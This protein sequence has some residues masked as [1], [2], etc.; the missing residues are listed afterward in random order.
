MPDLNQLRDIVTQQKK[1]IERLEQEANVIINAD[2]SKENANLKKELELS[3]QFLTKQSEKLKVVEEQNASLKNALFEQIYSEKLQILDSVSKKN[4]IYFKSEAAGELNRLA[5]LNKQ[6][7]GKTMKLKDQLKKYDDD[8]FAGL[9]NQLDELTVQANIA[10][11]NAKAEAESSTGAYTAYS[12]EQFEALK[13]EQITDDVV[14]EIGR[15]NNLEA[16][17][18]GNLINKAGIVFVILGI[19]AV[20]QLTFLHL[21][22]TFR[23]IIMFVISGVFLLG[24]E[25]LNRKKPNIFSLGV[26]SVGVAGIYASLSISYFIFEIITMIPALLLCILITAGAFVL[27]RRYSSQTIAIFALVGGYIP[28]IS[29]GDSITLI[30]SAMIYFIV[31]NLFSLALSFY[32][33]WKISMYF[34]FFLNLFGTIYIIFRVDVLWWWHNNSIMMSLAT[35]A[36]IL[37]AFAVY[38]FIPVL[39]NYRT[40]IPFRASDIVILSINTAVSGLIMYIVLLMFNFEAFT[41]AMA[42][43]FAVVYIGLGRFMERYFAIE[44]YMTALF[45]ITGLTFVVLVI[46]LQFG[47]MWLSLGWLTQ[48]VS[49]MCFGIL[50][51][52]KRL[53]RV[54]II[55]GGLCLFSFVFFDMLL[56]I[57]N[58]F[59][60]KYLAITLGSITVLAALMYKKSLSRAGENAY[61]YIVISNAWIYSMYL[62][63]RLEYFLWFQMREMPL[64]H[65]FLLYSIAIVVT[66]LFVAVV[67]RIPVILDTGV[68]VIMMCISTLGMMTLL[69]TSQTFRFADGELTFGTM[70]IATG[71]LIA[72]CVLAMFALRNVLMFFVLEKRLSVEWLP[73]GI[74][75][76]FLIVLTQNLIVQYDLAVTSMI[77]S[78]IFVIAALAWIIYG[79][80]KRFAFMRRF[81]LLL[82]VIAVAKLFLIDLQDLTQVSRIISFFAFGVTLLGISFV[83]QYFSKR[84]APKLESEYE[85]IMKGNEDV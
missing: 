12:N 61:K 10:F 34:G 43:I 36:Y 66:F 84:L 48:A 54:G 16:F 63:S 56:Q 24:G 18:G 40:K 76:F 23:A 75:A 9:F 11:V 19:I 82:S 29:I 6:L 58:L 55:I 60:Y 3:R 32:K 73:F 20:S 47:Q 51:S 42:I 37:L 74:S 44:K 39:S 27:S 14:A 79:F 5:R 26:T 69:R 52:D 35:I 22:E 80:V 1:L 31:L 64:N 2:L 33:S 72:L 4:D 70:A 25:L 71:I 50:K 15:K 77:L 85:S 30:Y 81:G 68:K 7:Q 57:D 28:I 67:P 49:L 59:L 45:Y 41:G 38:T 21:P 65:E 62:V 17:V 46:P 8:A 83:Y 78:I 53:K 13:N